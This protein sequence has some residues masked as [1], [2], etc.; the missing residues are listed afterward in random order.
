MF[1]K[2]ITLILACLI[3]SLM[4]GCNDE[5]RIDKAAIAET[6]TVCEVNGKIIYSFYMLGS[7]EKP[8]A[9]SV[10]ASSFEQACSLAEEEY[11]PNLFLA[12]LELFIV[13]DKL[14]N[15][16]LYNDINYMSRSYLISPNTIVAA[17]GE[18]VMKFISDSKEAPIKI[19]NY[20]I[21]NEKNNAD[22]KVSL[23]SILNSF[24]SL[25]Q[26]DFAISYINSQKEL[27]IDKLKISPEK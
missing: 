22:V 4:T 10:E 15:K 14:C 25:K 5:K 8:E 20:I 17:A 1:K 11:I 3:I 18:E 16:I 9:A 27:K 24:N 19:E 13:Q 12:K 21:L 6:V 26:E 23:L 2:I 7:E